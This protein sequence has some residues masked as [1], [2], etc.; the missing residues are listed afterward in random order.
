M[1][2]RLLV[3]LAAVAVVL[4]APAHA[5]TGKPAPQKDSKLDKAEEV[6]QAMAE[7]RR[8]TESTAEKLSLTKEFLDAFP[9]T[10]RTASALGAAFYYQG[11][12]IGDMPGAVAYAEAIR[13][14]I[15]DPEIAKAVDKEMLYVY[16]TSRMF[17]KMTEVA[18]RLSAGGSLDF[19]DHSTI[20]E[21]ATNAEDW[22]L[23]LEYCEKAG[24]FATPESYRKQYPDKQ[25]KDGEID[26]AVNNRAGMLLVMGGWAR[27]NLGEVDRALAD[28]AKADKLVSRSYFGTGEHNLNLYWGETLLM[29]GEHRA[30]AD[31]LA[32]D[33]LVMRDEKAI[34]GL[35]KA[36]AAMHGGEAGFEAYAGELHRSIAKSVGDFEL[37]DYA[38]KRH[39]MSDLR[40]DVTLLAFWFPT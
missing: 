13:G 39:R 9:E 25:F 12:D 7:K 32:A 36:Y 17:P 3:L 40:K 1:F 21:A 30:A 26:K 2:K 14:K 28:F 24:V 8:G 10:D 16:G 38:G 6:Y 23:A 31:K 27:A 20:I 33:A 4:S 29:K 22:K 11:E 35:K 19:S 34:A 18:G 15:S 37:A 5:Q